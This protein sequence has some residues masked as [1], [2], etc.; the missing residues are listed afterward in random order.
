M[1]TNNNISQSKTGKLTP[2]VALDSRKTFYAKKWQKNGYY[3]ICKFVWNEEQNG[4]EQFVQ[5]TS[6][7]F[8]WGVANQSSI[9]NRDWW[10][11][12]FTHNGY[13]LSF[14]EMTDNSNY[15]EY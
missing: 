15:N 2:K 6:G 4:Y 8:S 14:N 9:S 10:M 11:Y 3:P 13:I 1:A 5:K 7:W 12:I